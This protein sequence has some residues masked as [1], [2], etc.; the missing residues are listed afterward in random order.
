[1]YRDPTDWP[2]LVGHHR[3]RQAPSPDALRV[4]IPLD[5]VQRLMEEGH[6]CA[7]DLRCLDHASKQRLQQVCLDNCAHDLSARAA[8]VGVTACPAYGRAGLGRG[9][10]PARP[11]PVA[12]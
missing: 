8:L 4:E 12:A 1:M 2:P 10:R 7:A 5:L 9:D 11:V 3:I 6:I